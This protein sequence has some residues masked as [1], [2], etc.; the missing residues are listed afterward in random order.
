MPA[1]IIPQF[2]LNTPVEMGRVHKNDRFWY[3]PRKFTDKSG[4]ENIASVLIESNLNISPRSTT[5]SGN[6]RGVADL[7]DKGDI[8]ESEDEGDEGDDDDEHDEDEIF[9]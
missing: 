1:T 8:A 3:V 7:E 5:V 2:H 6:K 9:I 4:W